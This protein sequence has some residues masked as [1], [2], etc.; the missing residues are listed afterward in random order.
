MQ[1]KR[2]NRARTNQLHNMFCEHVYETSNDYFKNE[3][4]NIYSTRVN[5]KG[6]WHYGIRLNTIVDVNINFIIHVIN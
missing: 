6:G 4:Y 1:S 2:F 3:M 5:R